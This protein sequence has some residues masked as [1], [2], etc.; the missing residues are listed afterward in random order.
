MIIES[1]G[2]LENW[3]NRGVMLYRIGTGIGSFSKAS[4]WQGFRVGYSE[5]GVGS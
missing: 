3:N 1:N 2:K 5:F 4:D